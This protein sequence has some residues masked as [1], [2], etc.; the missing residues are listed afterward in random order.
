MAL[1]SSFANFVHVR[2]N[3]TSVT[4]RVVGPQ[5]TQD[6]NPTA[7]HWHGG[8]FNLAHLWKGPRMS[9]KSPVIENTAVNNSHKEHLHVPPR[10]WHQLPRAVCPLKDMVE[11]GGG[12][13]PW[14]L[15]LEQVW[16]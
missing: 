3:N 1:F 7:W 11:Q 2:L 6:K 10:A 14:A 5:I 12:E 4:E 15:R 16:R 13:E 8:S 9:Q